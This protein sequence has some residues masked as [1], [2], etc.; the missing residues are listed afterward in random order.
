MMVDF[1]FLFKNGDSH[2]CGDKAICPADI[3]IKAH[4][5]DADVSFVLLPYDSI[6]YRMPVFGPGMHPCCLEASKK[7]ELCIRD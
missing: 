5:G 7:S 1:A 2:G 3:G 6:V 4:F